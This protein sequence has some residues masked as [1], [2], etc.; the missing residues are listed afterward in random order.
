MVTMK[1]IAKEAG[2]SRP[3]VS[4]VLNDHKGN[5]RISEE[6][7]NRIFETAER[8]GYRRNELAISMKTG[9]TN[10]IVYLDGSLGHEYISR[11]LDGVVEAAQ[12]KNYFVKIINYDHYSTFEDT[13][14][15]VIEQRPAGVICRA[16][17][18]D[19][20]K[21]LYDECK[22]FGIPLSIIGG[23]FMFPWGIR[24]SPDDVKGA[25]IATDHLAKLGHKRIAYFSNSRGLGYVE[26]RYKG[27]CKVMA[28][29]KLDVDKELLLFTGRFQD[30]EAAAISIFS[31]K[32]RPT[33]VFCGSDGFAM[34]AINAA[35]KCGLKVPDDLSIIGYGN[36]HYS[37]MLNPPL[38]TI[39][40]PYEEVGKTAC[41]MLL[42]EIADNS[43]QSLQQEI[44]HKIGVKLVERESTIAIHNQ[45]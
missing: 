1:D 35:T 33:A 20:L 22:A 39:D 3:T 4:F 12:Q 27:F 15:H 42:K 11:S 21:A 30:V 6:T 10:F 24:V 29:N 43:I 45:K 40:E 14:K 28:K 32:D 34:I 16:T 5:V 13:V 17:A 18:G 38:T 41:N 31:H 9:K 25:E 7:R 44:R 37:Q 36:L 26:S 2:V 8:L 23:G 19:K